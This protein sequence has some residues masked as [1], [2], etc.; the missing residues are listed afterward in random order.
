MGIIKSKAR[1]QTRWYTPKY[2][3]TSTLA[4]KKRA[5]LRLTSRLTHQLHLRTSEH[6][7][8]ERRAPV[9]QANPS[10]SRDA[11]STESSTTSWPRAVTSPSATAPEV[12]LSTELSLQ[13]RTSSTSTLE[14]ASSPWQTP[15]Q[16][17]T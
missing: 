5:E 1:F 12:S 6:S 16:T 15:D 2:S 14:E 13:M 8:L 17:L 4:A 9:R 10:T 3:S 11:S 7:A